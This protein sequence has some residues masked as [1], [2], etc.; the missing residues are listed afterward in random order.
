MPE[1]PPSNKRALPEPCG[2]AARPAIGYAELHAKTNFSFL[3]GASHPDEL[4]LRAAEL[5]YQALAVTDR[6][7]LSGVVRAHVAAKQVGLKLIVGA[8]IT[9][10]DSPGV[11]LWTTDR[12]SYGR[13]ARLIT[14]GRR[15]AE[16]G[17]FQVSLADVAEHAAGLLAGITSEPDKLPEPHQVQ[18]LRDVF[19]DRC[20][21]LAELYLGPHDERRLDELV[22]LSRQTRVPLVAAGDVHFHARSRLAL[23]DVLTAT[24]LGVSVAEAGPQLFP[25]AERHLKPLAEMAAR[26][27]RLPAAL[28][29][30]AEIAQRCTFSLAE[31]RYEYP[32]ELSPPGETAMEYLTRLAWAGAASA[33]PGACRPS[34]GG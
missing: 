4:V 31:L 23:K 30:S 9:P 32:E 20:Y 21:L 3:E 33:I 24:R 10:V 19:G 12:A 14:V 5:G 17:E 22:E 18:R 26:F 2:P 16:K 1:I 8:E 34:C 11:V 27:A 13:L 15:R 29:R 25:N 6:N 7:T 28:A